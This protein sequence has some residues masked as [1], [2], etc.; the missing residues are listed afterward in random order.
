V[1]LR[2]AEKEMILPDGEPIPFV[3]WVNTVEGEE[4][5][6]NQKKTTEEYRSNWDNI[7]KKKQD[8]KPKEPT[9]KPSPGN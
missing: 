8:D 3:G 9:E 6:E 1:H 7:F 2:G 4:M 5:N